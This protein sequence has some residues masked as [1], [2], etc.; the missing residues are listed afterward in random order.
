MAVL[1]TGAGGFIG[2]AVTAHLRELGVQHVEVKHRWSDALELSAAIGT[3][4]VDSCLHLGWYANPLDYVTNV[5]GNLDALGRSL[6]LVDLL[7]RRGCGRLVVVGSAAEYAPSP[8]V[9]TEASAIGALSPYG[10][11]KTA[12]RTVLAGLGVPSEMTLAW[13]RLFNVTGPGEHP[14]R[15]LP[16][17]AA[18][19][20]SFQPVDLSPGDQVR[21]YLDVRD[22]ASALVFV[23]LSDLVGD[24]NVCSG[25]GR[26][27]RELLL[28]LAGDRAQLL[29]FGARA[30]LPTD[31]MHVVGDPS[32]LLGLGWRQAVPLKQTLIERRREAG[33]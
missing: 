6:E 19:L 18:T 11:T 13:A 31:S 23:L 17:V 1:I 29:R 26:S 4:A 8:D 24:V 25:R 9:L 22:V 14:A 12:L 21:D 28:E 5:P 15:L 10:A 27:L 30:Y 33:L 3:A 16:A 32:R 2:R 20:A 7:M